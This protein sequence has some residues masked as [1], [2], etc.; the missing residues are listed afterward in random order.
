MRGRQEVGLEES[1]R[2]AVSRHEAGR[3]KQNADRR[4][5]VECMSGGRQEAGLR[6]AGGAGRML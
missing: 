1:R 3:D 2:K 5:A 6:K 4:E